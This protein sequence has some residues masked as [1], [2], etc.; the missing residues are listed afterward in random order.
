MNILSYLD[1]RRWRII[2][3]VLSNLI[4]IIG[5]F[6]FNWR[7]SEAMGAY[8]AEFTAFSF[9]LV[10]NVFG[11]KAPWYDKAAGFFF[12]LF[13]FSMLSAGIMLF[14]GVMIMNYLPNEA[15]EGFIMAGFA[16]IIPQLFLQGTAYFKEKKVLSN[17]PQ[18][19]Y[20]PANIIP[21]RAT[22]IIL[23]MCAAAFLALDF[24]YSGGFIIILALLK[25]FFDLLK[26]KNI[27]LDNEN[28]A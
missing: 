28:E 10:F 12:W 18:A 9:F 22:I 21:N 23:A 2:I 17:S 20:A 15:N 4:P 7:T 24:K 8:W 3:V 1:H 14:F 11:A 5:V 27:K 13:Y 16:A 19:V 25:I 6:L 26:S